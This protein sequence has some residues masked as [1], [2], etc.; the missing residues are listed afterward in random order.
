VTL[1][2]TTQAGERTSKMGKLFLRDA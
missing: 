1:C 2:A